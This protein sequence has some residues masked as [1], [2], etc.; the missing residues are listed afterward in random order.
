MA[1]FSI[2]KK[3]QLEGALRLDAE[4]YQPE[5]LELKKVLNKYKPLKEYVGSIIH[6][7]E[8]KRE[9]ST[10]GYLFLLSQN[11]RENYLDFSE[12]FYIDNDVA[13][14]INKNLLNE[15][16]I[17]TV[18]T[19]NIGLSAVIYGLE[20]KIFASAD[21]LVIKDPKVSPFY[22]STFLNSKLG[23][24]YLR[25]IIY[26]ALQPHITPKLLG[27]IPLPIPDDFTLKEIHELVENALTNFKQSECLY[28]QAENLLLEELGLKD[29]KVEDNLHYIVNA[30]QIKSAQR[31]DAEYFQPK[32]ERLIERIKKFNPLPLEKCLTKDGIKKGIEIGSE[33]YQ[34]EGKLFIRVSN[35]S[36]FGLVERD[37]KY[38]SEELYQ[39]LKNNYEPKI[40]EI[41]LTKDAT[42]GTAYVV[43]EPIEGIIA[44]GIL[45]LKPKEEIEKEY[46]ALVL[47]SIVGKLQA[48][49]DTGG[50]V[51]LHWRPDQIKNCLIPI[52]PKTTQRE[53][54]GLVRQ[55]H[56]ARKKAK[57]LLEEAKR[58]VEEC[59]I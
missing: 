40:G 39:E 49:R 25:R 28:S 43:K 13:K 35:I 26:G 57:E 6:P 46:L 58:K 38:L 24:L 30:S 55:S 9:Y 37:Q 16:D 32:Y 47:N 45:R 19:G 14:F 10:S 42:P 53:I 23:K 3:S 1:I 56:E 51:I 17:V 44:G 34:E 4:Y 59:L 54:A 2:I 21:V 52:L 41:L 20:E 11:L 31:M 7:K 12:K 18:R 48:E 50:S 8:V 29:F 36:K 22:I 15:G 27:E 33:Q 5:Y